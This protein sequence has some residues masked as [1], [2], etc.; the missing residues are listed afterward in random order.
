MDPNG[1][2]MMQ[3]RDYQCSQ[4]QIGFDILKKHGLC[5][6]T[7]QERVGKSLTTLLIFEM[8]SRTKLLI[9]TKKAAIPDWKKLVIDYP[10][11][12]KEIEV[13]NYESI[14]K[15]VIT[16]DMMVLDEAHNGLSKYPKPSKTFLKV[17]DKA[18][19]LPLIYLSATPFAESYSQIYHQL[20]LSPW[21]PFAEYKSFYKWFDVF[22]VPKLQYL[23]SRQIKVYTET[24]EDLIKPLLQPIMFGLTRLEVGF[25]HEAE[26]KV[27]YIKL[28][29]ST[30]KSMEAFSK[31]LVM[32]IEGEEV[33]AESVGSLLVKLHQ[34]VGGTLKIDIG[35]KSPTQKDYKTVR[36]GNTEKID[37]IK[38]TW[39][40]TDDVVIMY[41]YKEEEHLLKEH[42]KRAVI[43]Q[44]D[45]YA[46]G[47]SLKQYKHLLIYSMSWRTSKYIQRRSRQADKD[48][49]EPIIVHFILTEDKVDWMIYDAV[50]NKK[51]NFNGRMFKENYTNG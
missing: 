4:A 39:G 41:H 26:D 35:M 40:D 7:S 2:I 20:R 11:E 16:P 13:I 30:E 1:P 48:R 14:H 43:L 29:E 5:Y 46:E 44:A 27:H 10:I 42:F 37:Y 8:S 25:K 23:G 19:G 18:W 31:N 12:G 21:S 34:M 49:E 15:A 36:L 38:K 47:I 50:V 32:E 33:L 6:N 45:R 17:A 22:G 3:P 24:R 9:V 51:E 28:D